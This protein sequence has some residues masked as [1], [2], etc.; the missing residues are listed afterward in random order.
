[1]LAM[2]EDIGKMMA[3]FDR[4]LMSYAFRDSACSCLGDSVWNT[5][6]LRD[7]SCELADVYDRKL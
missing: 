5:V 7:I 3:V 6:D 4:R 2:M 1:M